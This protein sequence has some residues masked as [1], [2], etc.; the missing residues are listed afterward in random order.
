M[1][2]AFQELTKKGSPIINNGLYQLLPSLFNQV[3]AF[4]V[5]YYTDVNIWGTFITY[6]LYY[7]FASNVLTWGNKDALLVRF[8]KEPTQIKAYWQQSFV[9]R[10]VYVLLPLIV[11]TYFIYPNYFFIHITTWLVARFVSQSVEALVIYNKKYVH[12]VTAELL[13]F[14][15]LLF[16]FIKAETLALSDIIIVF[17]TA[18]AI[19]TVYLLIAY[20]QWYKKIINAA[21]SFNLLLQTTPF[22]LMGLVAFFQAK[23]DLY[24]LSVFT[25]P[26]IIGQYQVLNSFMAFMSMVPLLILTPH[27]INLYQQNI[28]QVK[29]TQQKLIV[30]GIISGVLF[31]ANM[32]VLLPFLYQINFSPITFII[33]FGIVVLPF[34]YQTYIQ[35]LYK[36]NQQKQVLYTA[37]SGIGLNAALAYLLIPSYGVNGLLLSNLCTQMALTLCYNLWHKK[38]ATI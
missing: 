13:S 17:S 35:L 24:C 11:I 37:A 5:I 3:M 32:Y 27:I 25:T 4:L 33:I 6:Q 12:A 19:K 38:R 14:L 34:T 2:V 10:F 20:H 1:S 16:I 36:L 7:Y 8:A 21:V 30:I 23:V 9:T 22:M 31:S 28:K 26:N 29:N 15:P 18:Y